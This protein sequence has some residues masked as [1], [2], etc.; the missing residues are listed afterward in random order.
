LHVPDEGAMPDV[1]SRRRV[2]IVDDERDVCEMLREVLSDFDVEISTTF[3]DATEKLSSGQYD[4]AI[5]DI[6]GVRGH[7]LLARFGQSLPCIMFTAHAMTRQEL[8]R[9]VEGRARLFLPKEEIGNLE[10]HVRR[11]LETQ[12]PLWGW[13]LRTVDFRRWF[14]SEWLDDEFAAELGRR[15]EADAAIDTPLG[16]RE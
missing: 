8:R 5:L 6:M 1:S 9:S 12:E 13:L 10:A 3:E 16:A 11:V 4:V 14:G 15:D 2:L 7:A